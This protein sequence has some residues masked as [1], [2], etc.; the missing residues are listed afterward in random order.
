M[1]DATSLS[2]PVRREPLPLLRPRDGLPPVVETPAAL[3]ATIAAF[4]AGTGPVAIDA[5]RASGYRYSHRAYLV[6]LRRAGAGTALIDPVRCPDLRELDAVLADTEWVLHAASQDLPC[7]SE[8][9]LR[10][11]TLF[12]TEL[13]GRLLSY[14]R[15]GLG[16]L[17]EEILGHS[18][19]KGHSAVDWSTRPLPEP[20]LVYAALD[21]ELLVDL[22]HALSDSLVEAGKLEW[23]AQEFEALADQP[24][25][26][27]RREPW[28][29]TS[30][31]HRIRNRRELAYVREL[32]LARDN[33][34][35]RRDVSPGRV[36]SDQA[37][38]AAASAKPATRSQLAAIPQFDTRTTRRDLDQWWAAVQQA[39]KVSDS[40]LP[41]HTAPY[42]GPP[43]ARAWADRDPSA[44][45]RL[46]ACR[47]AL[48]DLAADHHLPLENLLAPDSVRRLAWD[49]PAEPTAEAVSAALR[50]RGARRWQIELTAEVLATALEPHHPGPP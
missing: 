35:E 1:T 22:R 49:P 5:E 29:R 21:V 16:A 30:G 46:A 10:P 40:E 42:D 24:P 2:G 19:E 14:P 13:A 4:A 39:R 36:L 45:A 28:R 38:I 12:D 26:E 44:A 31:I 7:L 41:E 48:H 9:G 6:Q 32:W 34:A 27:S 47:T 20:W 18:L 50:V 23:A 8:L 37:I 15:V 11:R 3:E 33:A 25:R 17:V 43:P